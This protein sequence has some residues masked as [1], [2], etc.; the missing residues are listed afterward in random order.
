MLGDHPAGVDSMLSCSDLYVMGDALSK[1]QQWRSA[2]DTLKRFIETCPY[3]RSPY[4][5]V[6]FAEIGSALSHFG[7]DDAHR[8]NYLSW[9]KSVLYLN[10]VDPE[11]FCACVRQMAGTLPLPHDTTAG[12]VSRATNITLSVWHWLLLNTS[13]DTPTL[14]Q[15]YELTRQTQIEQWQNDPT[16]YTLDTTLPP[17]STWGL[18]TLL[19]K[20]FLYASVKGGADNF[21]S[22]VPAYALTRNPTDGETELRFTLGKDAYLHVEV[23]DVLGRVVF[24]EPVGKIL[25][26]GEHRLPV[27]L[28]SA[29]A[30]TYYLTISLGTGEV[31]TIKLV[32]Q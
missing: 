30:G 15:N 9:L 25:S 2:F 11:Y 14:W 13:C 16:A 7:N 3:N 28:R 24:G 1:N 22:I 18:D 32:K 10:T 31:R 5:S 8:A 29:P 19:A 12:R 17:L 20:H 21:A 27:D 6:A 26:T 4:A 23:H